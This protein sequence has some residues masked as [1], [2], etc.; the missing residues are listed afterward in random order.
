MKKETSGS[1][2]LAEC[3]QD[4]I[5]NGTHQI[6]QVERSEEEAADFFAR[7]L[8][9]TCLMAANNIAQKTQGRCHAGFPNCIPKVHEK[10]IGG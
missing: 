2:G 1:C 8:E 10:A 4:V 9:L 5:F 6:T 7:R 3:D